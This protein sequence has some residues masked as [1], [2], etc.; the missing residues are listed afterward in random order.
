LCGN[1]HR[2][3]NGLFTG[4]L[5]TIYKALSAVKLAENLRKENLKVVPVFWIAEE[6]HDFDEVKKTTDLG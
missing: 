4:A 1:R 2:T 6:D 3:A 5:Y